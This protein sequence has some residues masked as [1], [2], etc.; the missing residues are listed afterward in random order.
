MS[1]GDKGVVHPGRAGLGR[2]VSLLNDAQGSYTHF[3]CGSKDLVVLLLIPQRAYC[4]TLVASFWRRLA[5]L[6]S[7]AV[8][9]ISEASFQPI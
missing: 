2:Q 7:L 8:T 1:C 5:Y 4:G 6:I 9:R 3:T